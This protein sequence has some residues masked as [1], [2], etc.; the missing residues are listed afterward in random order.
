MKAASCTKSSR[1]SSC[2]RDRPPSDGLEEIHALIRRGRGRIGDA[3]FSVACRQG[4]LARSVEKNRKIR[5]L[6][7]RPA[8]NRK[9]DAFAISVRP[10]GDAQLRGTLHRAG[11]Q[12]AGSLG[13][14]G[15]LSQSASRGNHD[16]LLVEGGRLVPSRSCRPAESAR[17]GVS[18]SSISTTASVSSRPNSNWCRRSGCRACA[19]SRP[20]RHRARAQACARARQLRRRRP[21]PRVVGS[22]RRARRPPL[23]RRREDRSGRRAACFGLAAAR[24]RRLRVALVVFQPE[25]IR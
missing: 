3:T 16:E 20:Q 21:R 1:R 23:G 12:E 19:R 4:W 10:L 14:G 11:D 2:S 22:F 7:T 9:R 13:P 6:R 15:R 25:P 17:I 24:C 5:S 8:R 18:A